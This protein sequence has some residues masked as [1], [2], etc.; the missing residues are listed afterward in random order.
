[1]AENRKLLE[2]TFVETFPGNFGGNFR[3]LV[4]VNLLIKHGISTEFGG[5]FLDDLQ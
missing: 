2:E 4:S 3:K 1:M 5:N